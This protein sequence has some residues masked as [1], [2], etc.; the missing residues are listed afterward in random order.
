[1]RTNRRG[2]RPWRQF[3]Y[4]RFSVVCLLCPLCISCSVFS[5]C[6]SV[7]LPYA[8][9][10][11]IVQSLWHPDNWLGRFPILLYQ[12]RGVPSAQSHRFPSMVAD[13][14]MTGPASSLEM[15]SK[16]SKM[17]AD[18][19]D[20]SFNDLFNQY[21][22]MESSNRDG[23][24]DHTV[25]SDLDQIFPF[26]PMSNGC[27]DNSPC[28][29][30]SEQPA[31]QVCSKEAWF[32]QQGTASPSCP[33]GF[34]LQDTFQPA[35]V[36][37]PTPQQE[38]SSRLAGEHRHLPT[39]PS[40][41]PETPRRKRAPKGVKAT[42]KP[43]RH[44]PAS[45]RC[46]LRRKQSFSPSLMGSPQVRENGMVFSDSWTSRTTNFNVHTSSDRLPLS[47]PP[48][49]II[50]KRE[51]IPVDRA[52]QMNRSG[53]RMASEPTGVPQYEANF[54]SQS[55]AL[56]MPSPS[57]E[58]LAR[59]QQRYYAHLST[60]SLP[61]QRPPSPDGIYSSSSSGHLP[62]CSWQ[63]GSFETPAYSFPS[64]LHNHDAR[65]WWSPTGPRMPEQQA[66]MHRPMVPSSASPS[67]FQNVNPGNQNG[68]LQGGLMIQFEPSLSS[69]SMHSA[70]TSQESLAYSN[71]ET[72]AGPARFVDA[73]SFTTPLV[74]DPN[75]PRSPSLSPHSNG[76]PN[77]MRNST[78]P[79]MGH[80]RRNHSR[81]LSSISSSSPKSA[82]SPKG[83]G[84]SPSVSFVN[85]TPSDSRRILTGVA[86]S[87]SSKTKARR[88]QEARE[89]RRKLSE[90]A[91]HAVRS[92]GGDV[93]A[94]E[95]VL[96]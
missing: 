78:T 42:P 59:Q 90:A 77:G 65:A 63:T 19:F 38:T 33:R 88:E 67:P 62:M 86:P 37:A 46:D 75:P 16:S 8:S 13:Q 30:T 58:S 85:F 84:K 74:H 51:N 15:E 12:P 3:K 32:L 26:D 52:A 27:G 44:R 24:K 79:T 21:V 96:C 89:K 57:S 76:S 25:S 83:H 17:L 47:P 64:D 60:S 56:S 55:P 95:A 34:V 23:N 66:T 93:E 43:V 73:S 54:F 40:T 61:S 45:D 48:S 14:S 4:G 28:F 9:A 41:P 20:H 22:N 29:P 6:Q 68:V 71:S 11:R 10:H 69:S 7:N 35:A 31:A 36:S 50:P 94:L 80:H 70:T 53:G 87:G 72:S 18:P 91:L 5:D 92:A 2:W 39:L 1:M 82:T 49:D 81:K